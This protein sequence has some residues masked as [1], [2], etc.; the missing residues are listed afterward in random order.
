MYHQREVKGRSI[1]SSKFLLHEGLTMVSN[2]PKK[3]R[4]VIALS[5]QRQ[6]AAIEG[7]VHDFKTEII[8]DYNNYF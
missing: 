7:E 4:N 1:H 5:S 8:L 3:N 6:G 2:I